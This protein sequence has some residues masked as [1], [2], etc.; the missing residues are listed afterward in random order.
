MMKNA[1]PDAQ[2]RTDVL[3]E[4][5]SDARVKAKGLHVAIEHGVV[6]L[7]GVVESSAARVAAQDAALRVVGVLDVANTIVVK[8]SGASPQDATQLAH[9][10]RE[11]LRGN[12]S[13]PHERIKCSVTDGIVTLQGHVESWAQ[14]DDV[15]RQV[16][17]LSGV[18]EVRNLIGLDPPTVTT[19]ALRKAIDDALER[20]VAHAAKH[21]EIAIEGGSVTLTGHVPSW[22]E[23][24]AI[25]GAVRGTRGVRRVQNWLRTQA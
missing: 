3:R 5:M 19:T 6:R 18:R 17:S 4:L 16:Q 2:I 20:H 13:L 14:Y 21:I 11:E 8:P 1:T 25:E 7:E 24:D 15:Q 12:A 10:V 22:A 23:R 9:A